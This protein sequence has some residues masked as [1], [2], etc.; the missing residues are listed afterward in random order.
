[1]PLHQEG[2]WTYE[3]YSALPDDGN[4]YEI[5]Y[6]RLYVTPSPTAGHQ[7]VSKR[8]QH[9]LYQLELAGQGYVFNAPTD[10]L[11]PGADPVQPDLVFLTAAQKHL[12]RKKGIVGPPELLVEI[13]SPGTARADRTVKLRNYSENG[14]RQYWI[15]DPNARTVEFLF[16]DGESYRLEASLGPG[17]VYRSPHLEGLVVDL[18]WLFSDLPEE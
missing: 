1:M 16:L 15:A 14:V 3:D 18:E 9:L 8:L 2:P 17:D 5:L 10:L 4:R 6:G 13:L 12:I 11:M 7:I